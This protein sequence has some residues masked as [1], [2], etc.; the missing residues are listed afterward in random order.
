MLQSII[1][2]NQEDTKDTKSMPSYV[3]TIKYWEK[4]S[5]SKQLSLVTNKELLSLDN[6]IVYLYMQCKQPTYFLA[7]SDLLL[8]FPDLRNLISEYNVFVTDGHVKQN[9][10]PSYKPESS[11]DWASWNPALWHQLSRITNVWISE[12]QRGPDCVELTSLYRP[13]H[14]PL[15]CSGT[16]W[17]PNAT[18]LIVS[19]Q[20]RRW[21][22]VTARKWKKQL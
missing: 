19:L 3:L 14:S 15:G 6:H 2:V 17:T 5:G 8:V 9:K 18:F 13:L 11:F 4:D 1:K 16:G 10:I 7:P 20:C 22:S 12:A 21:N